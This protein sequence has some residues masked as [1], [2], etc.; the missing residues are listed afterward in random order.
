MHQ[1]NEVF[2]REGAFFTSPQEDMPKIVRLFKRRKVKKV[3]DLGCGS[4]RHTVY[5]AKSGFAASG[6]DIAP[7]GIRLTREWLRKEN[8]TAKLKLGSIYEKLPYR[9]KSFDAIVFTQA[10]HHARIEDIRNAIK[11]MH[12]VLRPAGLIFVTVRKPLREYGDVEFIAP[13]TYVPLSG[14]EKGLPHYIFDKR[15]IRKEFANFDIPEIWL[16]AGRR[17]YCFVGRLKDA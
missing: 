16:D 10:L 6:L 12:R 1:W 8:Q 13:L 7:E 14:D 3:L 17:H 5:L 15:R 4:G 9:N 11:E 2:K